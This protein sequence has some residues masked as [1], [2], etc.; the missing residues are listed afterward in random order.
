MR[1]GKG[2]RHFVKVDGCERLKKK[3]KKINM[4]IQS[5]NE[6]IDLLLIQEVK[7]HEGCAVNRS[8]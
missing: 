2:R 7:Q 8:E 6:K 4:M 5:S 3:K 1:E